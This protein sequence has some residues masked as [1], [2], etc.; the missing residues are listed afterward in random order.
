VVERLESLFYPQV[1][2]QLARW[3]HATI[4]NLEAW[5]PRIQLDLRTPHGADQPKPCFRARE[6]HA[7]AEAE[8]LCVT[9][10][11]ACLLEDLST[12]RLFP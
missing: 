10:D 6:A 4:S 5:L 3:N 1:R 7:A 2:Q 11:R 12:E 8:E 9:D